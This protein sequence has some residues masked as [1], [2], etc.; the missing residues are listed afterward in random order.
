MAA[1]AEA[2]VTLRPPAKRAASATEAA[3]EAV[4][5]TQAEWAVAESSRR[6]K[7]ALDPTTPAVA[8]VD[9]G[10][11]VSEAQISTAATPS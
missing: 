10:S 5:P 6:A 9:T 2:A 7:A 1:V 8:A 3:Q 4:V 11:F